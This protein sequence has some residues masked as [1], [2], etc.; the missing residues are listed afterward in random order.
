MKISGYY[1]FVLLYIFPSSIFAQVFSDSLL[2]N[3]N[4]T[5][6]QLKS[7]NENMKDRLEIQGKSLNDISKNQSLTDKTKWEKIKSNV[8]RGIETY[9]ILSDD[10]I[11]LKSQVI[12][13]DY[14]GYIK[15]LSSV[16]DGPM[17]FSF[18]QVILR[19]AESKAVFSKKAKNERFM[20]T[21]KA[22]S[23]SP[24]VALIPFASQ[25]VT[26]S[27][28]ALN[29]AYAAGMQDKKVKF[30]NIKA[31]EQ[32]LNRYISYYTT[33]D[34]ANLI[35]TTNSAQTVGQLETLQLDVLDKMKKDGYKLG[36]KLRDQRSNES[37][38]EYCNYFVGEF[39][40]DFTKKRISEI[41]SKYTGK[42]NK[43]NLGELL[44]MELDI[45]H[46]HN[47]LDYVQDLTSRF[48][49]NHDS[50]FEAETRYF[51]AVKNAISLAKSNGI[52]EATGDKPANVVYEDL[53]KELS[54]KKIKK[55]NAIKSSINIKEL[56][57]KIDLVEIY[58][59]L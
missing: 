45:R 50:Y 24:L 7:E 40:T 9:K 6:K 8:T 4:S 26:L 22:L 13:Q 1:F 31:F 30:E 20:T 46:V 53:M 37:I 28:S 39:N 3:I 34:K 18:D 10:I 59:I 2:L 48:V 55:D 12:N 29:V 44:Q 21:L 41:E 25:A 49:T 51:D 14:Q 42:D 54:Q 57:D 56:K 15:K 11:D 16:K 36:L 5:M 52:I 38:D 43:I 32:D 17:G 35:N 33:L 27:S 47:N 23:G 19:I 58:K